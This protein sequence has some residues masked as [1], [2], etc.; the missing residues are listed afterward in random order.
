M[1]VKNTSRWTNAGYQLI[2]IAAALI[3]TTI[4]LLL[5]GAPPLKAYQE[6][7]YGSVGSMVNFSDVLVAWAPL[8]V[9]TA[10]LLVTFSAGLWN[11]G[12]EGQIILGAIFTTGALR[13]LQDSS[14]PA[15]LIIALGILAGILG[16]ILWAALVGALK[17]FGGVNEIFGGLGLNFIANALIL[18]LI[19]GPWRRPGVASLSGTVAFPA[20]L[21]LPTLPKLSISPLALILGI[22]SVVLIYI[23]LR[24]TH[25][26]LRLKAIGKNIHSSFTL[27]IPTWQY[28]M[29]SFIICGAF[30][31][32]TGAL[33][34]TG[35]YHR[36]LPYITGGYGFL[37]LLVAMLVNYQA[38]W[39]API[40]LFYAGL[41]IGS[42]QLPITLQLDSSLSGVLQGTLVLF[43]LLGEG[44]RQR[45]TRKA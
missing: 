5:S 10:G 43:V 28:M 25:I 27:G 20:K 32:L 14:L 44:I 37:G 9:T 23:L 39:V 22:L 16:G 29:L 1:Q 4:V 45:F 15:G 34:V 30:A 11:I 41:N 38:I 26:G 31:G 13:M 33:Q 7:I 12:I 19:Y 42:V 3:F 40:A 6:L 17:T 21:S 2:S 8:I 35:V 36:L 24:N 18:W